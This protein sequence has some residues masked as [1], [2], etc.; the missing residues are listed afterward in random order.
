MPYATNGR[1][2][3]G[4]ANV[5]TLEAGL[6]FLGIGAQEPNPSWGTIFQSGSTSLLDTWWVAVFPGLAI[7]ITVL[8][9]NVL[10]DALRDILAARQR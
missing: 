5:I 4:V 6:S 3:L 1:S 8:A 2:T 9:F 10:G 7:L